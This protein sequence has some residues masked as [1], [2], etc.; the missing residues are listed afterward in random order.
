MTVQQLYGLPLV[1]D[2]RRS[3][4]Q[5]V[6]SGYF[7]GRESLKLSFSVVLFTSRS[8]VSVML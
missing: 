8:T 5:R 4:W 6:G 1:G 3:R 2:N 7:E